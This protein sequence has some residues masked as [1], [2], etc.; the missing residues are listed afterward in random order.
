MNVHPGEMVRWRGSS[1]QVVIVGATFVT[2]RP[3]DGEDDI[4]VLTADLQR[5]AE[6]ATVRSTAQLVNLRAL[7]GLSKADRRVVDVWTDALD[8]LDDMVASGTSKTDAY[9]MTAAYVN[10]RL[11]TAYSASKVQRQ[12]KALREHGVPGLLDQRR[13]GLAKPR[14]RAY[15]PRLIEALVTVLEGQTSKATGTMNRAIWLTQY[16]LDRVHG[17]GVVPMP[18]R[19]TMYRIME[20]LEDGRHTFGRAPTRR[21]TANQP[22]HTHGAGTGM[23]P[24]ERVLIDTTPME[25]LVDCDGEAVR[26]D[27]TILLD[28]S[29]RSVLAA[30]VT[31]GTRSID[32]IVILARALVPYASRP[33]GVR[34]YRRTVAE[35]WV[36]DD[37]LLAQ[38]FEDHRDAQPYIFPES[39][40]TDH[41]A[42]YVSRHFVD[43]CQTLGISLNLSASY[44]P[45]HK[46]KVERMFTTV[47]NLFTQYAIGFLGQSPDMRGDEVIPVD[48]LLT[49]E[50][51]QELLDDW[52]A[53]AASR[54]TRI[55]PVGT[56][57]ALGSL[58]FAIHLS[59]ALMRVAVPGLGD[60]DR[61]GI[62]A[63]LR[64]VADAG[65]MAGFAGAVARL[66]EALLDLA[67]D[68][69]P[70]V[71]LRDAPL[72]I[73]R[74]LRRLPGAVDD[75]LNRDTAAD[76]IEAVFAGDDVRAENGVLALLRADRAL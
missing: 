25:I 61:A 3:A 5:D 34:V 45:T 11:G 27:L 49:L 38:R 4:E 75:L 46:A 70:V 6:P 63:H 58:S 32:L 47:K 69:F 73:D 39:I 71:L 14:P 26:P 7:D 62:V 40:T 9:A 24:G 57:Q 33:E 67:P 60:A 68:G 54:F 64:A 52:I 74:N 21:S 18:S 23:R 8:Q 42:T 41:G 29:S 66:L 36:G 48:Q 50:Q 2:L 56:Q 37:D 43:A 44:T 31:V 65:D 19:S 72:A 30:V 53:V 76:L 35:A 20:A 10:T 22:R 59:A 13:F 51:L 12:Q 15:D 55:V 16:E 28:E 17:P 1:H